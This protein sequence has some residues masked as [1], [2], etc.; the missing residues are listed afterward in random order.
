MMLCVVR[1]GRGFGMILNRDNRQRPMA[2][3]FHA[4]VIEIDVRHFDFRWQAVGLDCKAMIV[5]SDLH[6]PVAKIFHRLIAT[7]MTEH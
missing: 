5:R 4:L 1:A 3:A 6:V 2:H 7:A